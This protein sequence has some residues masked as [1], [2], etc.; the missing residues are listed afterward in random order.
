MY[1]LPTTTHEHPSFWLRNRW[2]L[3][4]LLVVDSLVLWWWLRPE[5]PTETFEPVPTA[6]ETIVTPMEPPPPPPGLVIGF[7][8]GQT[9]LLD[10]NIAG[11]F[12][13]TASGRL[14]SALYGST[15]TRQQGSSVL[16]SFHE[17]ID[18][19]PLARDKKQVSL[20]R[21]FAIADGRVAHISKHPGNSNYGRYV[22]LVHDDP[23]GE[24]YSLYAH[25]EEVTSSLRVGQPVARGADIGRMGYSPS[26]IIPVARSH[27][28]LEV[29]VILSARFYDW[30][31]KQKLKP[32]HGIYH[33]HNLFGVDPLDVYR[34]QAA[35]GVFD[36]RRYLGEL[37][38]AFEV[39]CKTSRRP[40]YFQRYHALWSGGEPSG[41]M[42][43]AVSEGGVPMRGRAATAEE[44]TRL[45]KSQLVVLSV[46]EDVLGRNGQRLITRRQ[47]QWQ[48]GSSG[49]RWLEVL[50]H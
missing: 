8:T 23:M 29:G 6:G 14:E 46:N 1:E 9:G 28:H 39:V 45:G 36:M 2:W 15:R 18:I 21:I 4:P 48:T 12:M 34:I 47:G 27:L 33:G 19:A 38:V 32:D 17:G 50:T 49:Q 41:G 35:R 25:L 24:I 42:V 7:P 37:P 5:Q 3:I 13:P 43:I 44:L 16:P 30:F 31:K 10:T 11:V 26:S 40:D 22:V 20:D